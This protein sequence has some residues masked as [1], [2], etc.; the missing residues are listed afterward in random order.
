MLR[1][2]V[3]NWRSDPDLSV[4]LAQLMN[5]YTVATAEHIGNDRGTPAPSRTPPSTPP[6]LATAPDLARRAA[7]LSRRLDVA[8]FDDQDALVDVLTH[9]WMTSLYSAPRAIGD[10]TTGSDLA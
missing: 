1:A 5:G 7:L 6:A 3:E 8:P 10:H 2:I 9:I 4:A